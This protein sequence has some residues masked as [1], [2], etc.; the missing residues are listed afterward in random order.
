MWRRERERWADSEWMDQ[1]RGWESSFASWQSPPR[2]WCRRLWPRHTGYNYL[3]FT[4]L[5]EMVSSGWQPIQH[6]NLNKWPV[7]VPLIFFQAAG[8]GRCWWCLAIP[9]RPQRRVPLP[10]SKASRLSVGTTII[11]LQGRLSSSSCSPTPTTSSCNSLPALSCL[12][13]IEKGQVIIMIW[14]I[15]MIKIRMR[16]TK[17]MTTTAVKISR[18]P[19]FARCLFSRQPPHLP[20]SP[21]TSLIFTHL[22]MLLTITSAH[23]AIAPVIIIS[24]FIV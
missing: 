1:G 6:D 17:I 10:G 11:L 22:L 7:D 5:F 12:L 3:D 4:D 2:L 8:C 14:M 16:M 21:G 9:S 15:M 23:P 19:L 18:R 13:A 24:D 20:S